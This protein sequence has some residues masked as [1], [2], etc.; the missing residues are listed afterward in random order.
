MNL[1][2]DKYVL[3]D[4]LQIYEI[5]SPTHGLEDHWQECME[6]KRYHVPALLTIIGNLKEYPK[7]GST[8][9]SRPW[10]DLKSRAW[11]LV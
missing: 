11:M 10:S 5:V 4:K 7:S 2:T 9:I 6:M 3:F 1:Q 8:K